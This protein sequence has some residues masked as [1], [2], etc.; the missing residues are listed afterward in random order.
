MSL[1]WEDITLIS[2][3]R[4]RDEMATIKSLDEL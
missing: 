3:W 1:Y 2:N 4:A